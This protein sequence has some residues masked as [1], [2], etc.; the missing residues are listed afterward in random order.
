LCVEEKAEGKRQKAKY[1]KRLRCFRASFGPGFLPCAFLPCA[2]FSDSESL[3]QFGVSIR[4]FA[5]EV[6]EQAAAL[7][8]QFEEPAARVMILRVGF[9]VFG[10]VIDAFA[11]NRHL[12]FG[13]A[14]VRVVRT[15]APDE[16]V[17]LVF[18]QCHVV[19]HERARTY[20]PAV[21]GD[22]D[23]AGKP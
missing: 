14:G 7:P 17:F 13:G 1:Q 6:I 3:D 4:V 11:E 19:L 22:F 23:V 21:Y 5:L 12:N 16:R 2:L 10:Q 8:D 20:Q 9:E 18:R 15:V